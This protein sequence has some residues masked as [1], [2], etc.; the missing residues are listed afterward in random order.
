MTNYFI[1][2]IIPPLLG[3]FVGGIITYYVS[4]KAKENEIKTKI[5]SARYTLCNIIREDGAICAQ[6]AHDNEKLGPQKNSPVFLKIYTLTS[7]E[8]LIKGIE[9]CQFKENSR[10]TDEEIKQII[11]SY[12]LLMSVCK[13]SERSERA[14]H[15]SEALKKTSDECRKSGD[16][17]MSNLSHNKYIN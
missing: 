5:Y 1:D 7:Y 8:M 10:L 4:L 12:R 9:S 14:D 11:S 17:L 16:I 13:I 6:I 2:H 15:F 3:V